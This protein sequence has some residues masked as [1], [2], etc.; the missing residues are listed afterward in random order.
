MK[1]YIFVQGAYEKNLQH[2]SLAIPRNKLVVFTGVSGSGKTTL[3][4]DVLFQ[5]AQRQYLEAMGFQGMAKPKV[6]SITNLS[7]A[8]LISQTDKNRNPRSTVGTVT[9]MY[10]DLRLVFEKISQR[11]CPYCAGSFAQSSVLDEVVKEQDQVL[12]YQ[13]CPH[14]K[15]QM[16]KLT[17]TEFSFNTAEGACPTCQGLGVVWEIDAKRVLHDGLSLDEGAVVFWKQ[18]YKEYQIETFN[19]ALNHY[20][21]AP[22]AG[23][24]LGN[25]SHEQRTL[26][27]Y[28][29]GS[30]QVKGLFPTIGLPKT[31]AEG[32]FE[33]VYTTLLRRI[34]EEKGVTKGLQEFFVQTPC[35]ACHGERLQPLS[36]EATLLGKRLPEL[37]AMNVQ[38]L[39]QWVEHLSQSLDRQQHLYV[40][41]YL[42][43]LFT[44]LEGLMQTG[45]GYL[46]LDRQTI[47]LSSG[48]MQRLRLSSALNSSLTGIIYMLDEPTT[49]LHPKDT[50]NLITQMKLLR[51]KGNTVLVIEHDPTVMQ[52]A[53]MIFDLGPGAGRYGG[54]L[55][56]SGTLNELRSQPSSVTGSFRQK[57]IERNPRDGSQ[58]FLTVTNAT[59]HNLHNLTVQFPIGCLTVVTG[60]SGSGKTTLVFDHLA[61]EP[62]ITS[63]FDEVVVL[64][65][66]SIWA[67][68]RSNVATFMDIYTPIRNL[69]AQEAKLDKPHL[70]AKSFSFNSKGGRCER[71][72]GLGSI[73]NTLLFFAS[74]EVVCPS[75]NGKRFNEEVLSVLHEG[76]SINDILLLTVEEASH[77]FCSNWPIQRLLTIL[78]DVGLGYLELGQ[79]IPT[80]SGGEAQRLKLAR[81]LSRQKRQSKKVLYLMDEPTIGL[82]PQDV[83]HFISLLQEMVK[84]GATLIVVEHNL[85]LIQQS[86]WI[87]DLGPEGGDKGGELLYSGPLSGIGSASNSYTAR[88]LG[89]GSILTQ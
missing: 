22:V 88:Y 82:H 27:L 34:A 32:K 54:R 66:P 50:Q 38:D 28:G 83:E 35:P 55:I 13:T 87:V 62:T 39:L 65:Q 51:D 16:R 8:V 59:R 78:L 42:L 74:R 69:F 53:D 86:D 41:S 49:G 12:V 33:G 80:L 67:M 52:Q 11:S 15:K 57:Q 1:E 58:L 72:E 60:V 9:D 73:E 18:R 30:E 56:G 44:K 89:L 75:C 63:A 71:C 37:S 45:L 6:E 4:Y 46:C 2:I 40:E 25:F 20:S 85:Q 64:D 26:L 24:K 68:K 7:P 19:K 79:T 61:E 17:C 48:E 5:E 47:T 14:C 70:S 29:T 84:R 10:T 81:A 23:L 76:H 77:L 31:Q 3:L 21:L 36:R 43:A